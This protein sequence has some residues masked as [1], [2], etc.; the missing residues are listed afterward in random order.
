MK[1]FFQ[2]LLFIAFDFIVVVTAYSQMTYLGLKQEA[3]VRSAQNDL[4]NVFGTYWPETQ[5]IDNYLYIPTK[6]GLYR[7]SLLNLNDTIWELHSFEG[8]PIRDFI[9]NNDTI[10]VATARYDNSGL[11][12]LSTNNG[13]SYIDYTPADFLN[14]NP[15]ITILRLA[16]NPLNPQKIA[17]MHTGLGVSLSS[18]FG[19]T[20]ELSN[21]FLGGYQD[22]FLGFNPNDTANIFYTGEQIFFQSYIF[23][24][25]NSGDAWIKVDSLQ[26]HCTHGIAFHP[27]NK[28]IMI[29]YGEG[30]FAKSTNQGQNWTDVGSSSLYIFKTIFDP[31]NPNVLYASGDYSGVNDTIKIYKSTD[32]GDT[33]QVF[34]EEKFIDSDGVMDIHLFNNKLIVYTLV[35]G[36]YYLDLNNTAGIKQHEFSQIIIYPNPSANYVYIKS[37]NR[38]NSVNIV[39]VSGKLQ[40]ETSLANKETFIDVA[41]LTSGIYFIVIKT[42]DG[43][44]IKKILKK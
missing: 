27:T 20:W 43:H 19:Q 44:V 33:W 16:Q 29:S 3:N 35:N 21:Y 28:D 15:E 37:D 39:D 25:Y 31:N 34:Y 36:V 6:N 26:T 12:L 23:S 22:W 5:I 11:L 41:N 8:I 9:K 4:I 2:I 30:R 18:D 1:L 40:Y 14:I 10:L 13:V 17:A 32:L 24:S 38:I 42:E 7:K